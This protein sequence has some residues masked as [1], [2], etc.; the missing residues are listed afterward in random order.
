MKGYQKLIK[1][2]LVLPL[3]GVLGLSGTAWAI[4]ALQI[5]I[6]GGT[7]NSSTESWEIETAGPIRIWTIG[8]IGD[9]GTIYDVKLAVAYDTGLS[10]L[11][12]LNS[13]TTGGFGGV[14]DPLAPDAATFI[15][16]SVDGEIPKLGGGSNL[17]SHGIYQTGTT[18]QEFALGDF[19]L[20]DSNIGDWNGIDPFPTTLNKLGQVNV[21]V[22]AFSN[23]PQGTTF[24]FDLYD[25]IQAQNGA[26]YINAPFSHDGDGTNVHMP[27]PGTIFLLG[28]GLAGLGFWRFRKGTKN[29][30]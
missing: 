10:P 15:R 25:H 16:T 30:A 1:I 12:F 2:L 28:S 6:E 19:T 4:P 26:R 29:Q 20:T 21:Y 3:V 13:T 22:F 5:Y 24:H 7:Y 11:I 8:A 27:E 14:L 23:A 17:P 9:Y 18:F